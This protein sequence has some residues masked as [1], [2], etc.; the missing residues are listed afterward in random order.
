[1]QEKGMSF[2]NHFVTTALCCP[3]RVSLLTGRQTH[4]TNVTDV[5]PPWGGYPKFISQ[6][7]NDNFLPVWM[8]N[9]VYDTYYTGKL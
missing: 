1:M 4:N 6:G 2:I 3:S 9:A 5:H 7:F 8:Q